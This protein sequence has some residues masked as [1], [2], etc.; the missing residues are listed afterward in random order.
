[1]LVSLQFSLHVCLQQKRGGGRK[2]VKFTSSSSFEWLNDKIF[3]TYHTRA[4]KWAS[5]MQSFSPKCWAWAKCHFPSDA[6]DV[7]WIYHCPSKLTFFEVLI[8]PSREMWGCQHKSQLG[9]SITH[10]EKL[11]SSSIHLKRM[12]SLFKWCGNFFLSQQYE[13][14]EGSLWAYLAKVNFWLGPKNIC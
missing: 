7:I 10:T 4:W 9:G 11:W 1:M 3:T 8:L 2:T 5:V 12:S 6:W 13:T 14:Q